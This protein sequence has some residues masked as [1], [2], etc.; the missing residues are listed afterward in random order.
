MDSRCSAR[1]RRALGFSWGVTESSKSYVTLS[2]VRERDLASILLEEAGTS[3]CFAEV[4]E[5]VGL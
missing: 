4:S 1:A 5:R 2:E 3:G